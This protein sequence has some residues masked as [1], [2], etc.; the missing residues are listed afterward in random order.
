[1]R[2]PCP[3]LVAL[4]FC[5]ALEA[6]EQRHAE[7]F[8][9]FWNAMR[10]HYAYLEES[11]VDWNAVNQ[12]YRP[13]FVSAAD[14]AATI[15]LFEQVFD[16]LR[17][18]H[19]Q[20]NRNVDDSFRLVPS[21]SDLVARLDGDSAVV[22]HVRAG[23]AAAQ[24]G[25]RVGVRIVSIQ[26]QTVPL[27][28]ER[29]LGACNKRIDELDRAWAL[30]SALAGRRDRPR[31]LEVESAGERRTL[32]IEGFT[33]P[34][35]EG[36]L[37][38]R[39]L[40]DGIGYVRLHDSLGDSAM[41]PAFD[42]ALAALRDTRALILDLRDTPSGGNTTNARSLLGRFVEA[43][44][45]YQKHE[46]A[47]EM[48]LYGVN[49]SWLE[50]VSPRGPFAYHAPVVVL[51][52]PWTGS[53]GEGVA[54]AFDAMKRG[55][56]IGCEMARLRGATDSLDLGL[57]GLTVWFP[58]ERLFHVDGTPR[59]R[60]VPALYVDPLALEHREQAD[61]TLARALEFLRS[62]ASK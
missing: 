19:I 46:L 52:D 53:M 38:W 8:D 12:I 57:D 15:G 20:L 33:T 61:P 14:D 34:S 28:I 51:V 58:T 36:P 29:R 44:M 45:P 16:E 56:V 48:R 23:S 40:D 18:A 50:L 49:R 10:D 4:A 7:A 21:G 5:G 41:V 25:F 13:M 26:G 32:S 55:S 3:V 39:K 59:H 1:M 62:S 11:G 43:E 2:I 9:R 22:T 31:V 54:I 24:A 27:A 6:R 35:A 30:R 37:E 17:D 60:F 47:S 42:D